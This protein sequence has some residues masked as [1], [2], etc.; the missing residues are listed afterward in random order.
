MNYEEFQKAMEE[1][2]EI[3]GRCIKCNYNSSC[4]MHKIVGYEREIG[5]TAFLAELKEIGL[6][7]I[8]KKLNIRRIQF[9]YPISNLVYE[10]LNK[11]L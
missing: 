11:P 7:G 6:E 9:T 3:I 5:K 8:E 2:E 4:P 1:F 10:F